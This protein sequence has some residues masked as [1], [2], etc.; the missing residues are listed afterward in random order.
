MTLQL[1]RRTLHGTAR[2]EDAA[3]ASLWPNQSFALRAIHEKRDMSLKASSRHLMAAMR[4][5]QQRF[6]GDLRRRH[7][8]FTLCN[9]EGKPAFVVAFTNV[10][11][12]ALSAS[13][14]TVAVL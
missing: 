11:G 10:D 9:V 13:Y 12:F 8:C 7:C 2:A 3:I 4:A 14:F 1:N 5:S 6:K